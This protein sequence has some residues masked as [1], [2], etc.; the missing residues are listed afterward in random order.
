MKKTI[1]YLSVGAVSIALLYVASFYLLGSLASHHD[2]INQ[3]Y[4]KHFYEMRK[5]KERGHLSQTTPREGIFTLH[6][7]GKGSISHEA[8]GGILFYVP[9]ELQSHV[10]E[11]TNGSRVKADIGPYL[12]PL[13]VGVYHYEL[14]SITVQSAPQNQSG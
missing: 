2:G 11:I 10:Q 13:S 6:Q 3:F 5:W 7:D 4:S 8:Y 12:S 1:K 9:A 14:R